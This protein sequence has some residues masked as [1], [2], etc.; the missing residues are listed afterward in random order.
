M[1]FLSFLLFT[2][3]STKK[4]YQRHKFYTEIYLITNIKIL[5]NQMSL[6][7]NANPLPLCRFMIDKAKILAEFMPFLSS[8]PSFVCILLHLIYR[9]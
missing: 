8:F 7:L 6:F 1:S 2:L 5:D 9:P 3:L 4:W